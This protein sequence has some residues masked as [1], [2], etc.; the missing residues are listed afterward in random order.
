M[1]PTLHNARLT[2]L[3]NNTPTDR[4]IESYYDQQFSEFVTSAGG[5]VTVYRVYGS[6]PSQ[7]K[8]VIK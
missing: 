5:D 1:N 7:F 8:V 2:F 3:L 6:A 4:V